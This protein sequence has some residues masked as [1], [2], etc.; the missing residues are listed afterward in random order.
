MAQ[1]AVTVDV[2]PRVLL[3]APGGTA[4]FRARVAGTQDGEVVW[5]ATGGAL[6]REGEPG[7]F[8]LPEAPQP[9]DVRVRAT[10]RRDPRAW[11][12]AVVLVLPRGAV[13]P[14]GMAP[15]LEEGAWSGDLPFRDWEAPG[16][17]VPARF[18]PQGREVRELPPLKA[19]GPFIFGYGLAAPLPLG[20]LA[21]GSRAA[22]LSFGLPSGLER[23]DVTGRLAVE[24]FQLTDRPMNPILE[25]LDEDP[26]HP[27]A[28]VSRLQQVGLKVRG[29]VP[30]AGNPGH[31]GIPLKGRGYGARFLEPCGIAPVGLGEDF[32]YLVVDR[33]S[34]SLSIVTAQGQV[35]PLCGSGPG[36]QDGAGDK[37]RFRAPTFVAGWPRDAWLGSPAGL[38]PFIVSDTGNHVL[39]RVEGHGRVGT[40]AGRPGEPGWRDAGTPGQA[41]FRSPLGVAQ[42]LVGNVY[43]ADSGNHVIRVIAFHGEVRTLAGAPGQAGIADGPGPRARFR[44]LKGLMLHQGP[45]GSPGLIYVL[46]G[47]ALREVCPVH[48]TVTTRLGR[49]DE[50]AF[51]DLPHASPG[52]PCLN[53]PWDLA[54]DG[55]DTL[56]IV[57]RGNASVR[58]WAITTGRLRTLAGEPGEAGARWGLCSDQAPRPLDGRY[59]RLGKPQ[60]IAW[61]PK[62]RHC[63]VVSLDSCLGTLALARCEPRAQARILGAFLRP[64]PGPGLQTLH[65]RFRR[66]GSLVSGEG[67]GDPPCSW[68][69]DLLEA[70]EPHPVARTQGRSGSG[71]IVL[72]AA[73]PFPCRWKAPLTA[74][75]TCLTDQG[76]TESF[77]GLLTAETGK[78]AKEGTPP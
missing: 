76:Y 77:E 10:S 52:T 37:A 32:R 74:R 63:P 33:G 31:P 78:A 69:L 9:V 35:Q 17:A 3:A 19:L 61:H 25:G 40:L 2:T 18:G 60:G 72:E 53:D 6:P 8:H 65:L 15:F 41:R 68:V 70:M 64:G 20:E 42:D 50:A 47:H 29:V 48:G 22:L 49:V 4:A 34:H 14:R 51:L 27:G 36:Y 23:R 75:I 44:D 58:E 30:L 46:D 67:H 26:D 43:V 13:G 73:L 59:A 5:T 56:L 71:S 7:A 16:A 66:P 12:E 39:R 28:W 55:S 11:G 38:A 62:D 1:A 45:P 21:A 24:D 54:S 57:D